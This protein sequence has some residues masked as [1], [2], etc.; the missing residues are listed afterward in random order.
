MRLVC[1]LFL[2]A[3]TMLAVLALSAATASAQLEVIDEETDE[4]CPPVV[5]EF[6]GVTGGCH[7]E[8]KSE[9]HITFV[10]QTAGGPVPFTKCNWHFEGRVDEDG[11]GYVT[12]AALTNEPPPGTNPPCNRTPC[13]ESASSA[14]PHAELPWTIEFTEVNALETVEFMLCFRLA[15]AFGG[16]EGG[17]GT[18]C[19]LHLPWTDEGGHNYEIGTG[20]SYS[21]ENLPAVSLQNVH[22][23][24]E[25]DPDSGTE[26]MEIVH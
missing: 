24:N 2:L 4:S 6:H 22:F 13:D 18:P 1:K 3:S 17:T 25:T 20:A 26:D 8:F 10:V 21:C 11:A 7:V 12:A 5:L 14:H 16:V 19:E 23:V 9:N 15:D